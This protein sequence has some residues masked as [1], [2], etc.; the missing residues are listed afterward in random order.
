MYR[1]IDTVSIDVMSI[2]G[3]YQDRRPR[4]EGTV[5]AAAFREVRLDGG[6]IRYREVGTYPALVFV[7]GIL[8][9]GTLWRD[10]VA[11]LSGRIRCIVPDLPLGG[12]S[13]AMEA[14]ADLM[15]E[16]DLR[17]VTLVGNDTGGAICQVLISNHPECIGTL[18]LS[19]CDAYEAFFPVV[20]RPNLYAARVF[21]MR[22][23]A[24]SRGRSGYV[25]RGGR[26]SK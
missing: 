13:V 21:G 11:D 12:H 16:L 7:H 26:S 25:S 1:F 8:A 22:Y 3:Y 9:N 15:E 4:E 14:G 10:V 19:N 2:T 23:V 17:D 5:E 20:L 6:V 24:L 18:V